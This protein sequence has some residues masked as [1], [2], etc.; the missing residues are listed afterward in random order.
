MKPFEP[1]NAIAPKLPEGILYGGDYN[2]EQWPESVW[3]E[4]AEL[5][6]KAGVNLV[7]VAIFSWAKLEPRPREYN[8]EWL[9]RVIDI[10]WSRGVS[11][12][13]ATATASPPAWFP[14]Q[15]PHS[16]PVDVNGIRLSPGSRQHY[17]PNCSSY[18]EAGGELIRRVATR[19][20]QHPAVALWHVNNEIGCHTF[21]C[22]CDVCAREFRSWLKQRYQSLERLNA[23][24]GTA[25]WSQAYGDWEEILPPRKMPTFRNPGHTLDY[26]RFMSDS[27]RNVLINEIA[28]IRSITPDAKVTTNGLSFHRPVDYW[29]WYK[30]VDIAAWD[31][32]PDPSMELGD[33]R[34]AAFN[35]DLFRSLK[36]G[37][38]F[39]LMEQATTQVNWRATNMLKAP[40]QM[41]ALSMAA[42]A[43]GADGVMFFQW[44]A[45]Q[46]GAEKF[47][48]GMVPHFGTE[49]RVFTEVC[50]LGAELKKLS[51]VRGARTRAR[52]ALIVSWENRWALELESKP[53]TFD[54]AEI[55]QY[56]YNALWDLN[57]AV[58]IVHPDGALENY[59]LVVAPALYQMTQ[60]QGEKIREF[61]RRGGTLLMSYFSG[62]ADENDRIWLGGYPGL[63][64]DVLGLAVEEWQPLRAGETKSIALADGGNSTCATFCELIRLR[65]AEALA[66]YAEDFYIGSPAVTKNRYGAGQAYYVATQTDPNWFRSFLQQIATSVDVGSPVIA[67]PGVEVAC[68]IKPGKNF[69]FV[70]NHTNEPAWVDFSA[71]SGDDILT[72]KHC[73][74]RESIEPF[75][76]KILTRTSE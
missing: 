68:R 66:T 19:Y 6:R 26:A 20:A 60:G 74:A 21:E 16:L 2:P 42:I 37:Q 61:V 41:R 46:A 25:F 63:L 65:G 76:V 9:D 5:M 34:M 59:D 30:E 58:D 7:S 36:G 8:F 3:I 70:I 4:D 18:R 39:I 48:S 53:T 17:C 35:H 52:V 72:G 13:L 1:L 32:Y 45:S 23:A 55:V 75:G 28:A 62:I 56:Y 14:R 54:Y 57:I 27:L 64:R 15:Y 29:S 40:G 69:L 71:W 50:S 51:E 11:V 47:H 73:S 33:A 49:G 43:R 24:W 31:S 38:P 22:F 10:L 44:R 67:S 12:C